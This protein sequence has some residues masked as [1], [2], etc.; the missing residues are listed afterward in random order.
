MV[1]HEA[2]TNIDMTIATGGLEPGAIM[3]L[4]FA[5]ECEGLQLALRCK[6]GLV[7]PEAIK[8]AAEDTGDPEP[9]LALGWLHKWEQSIDG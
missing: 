8:E 2:N 7:T 4:A 6:G 5:T 9:L 3:S 1:D